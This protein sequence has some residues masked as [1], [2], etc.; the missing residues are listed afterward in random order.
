MQDLLNDNGSMRLKKCRRGPMRY[1]A[2]DTAVG[3]LLDTYGEFSEGEVQMLAKLVTH[4][5][6]V[7]EVGAN[8]G[9]LTVPLAQFVGPQGNVV[10]FEPQRVLFQTLCANVALNGLTNVRTVHAA[11]GAESGSVT[12]PKIDYATP[13][14]FGAHSIED[15]TD[16]EQ[17]QLIALDRFLRTDRCRLI[18]IDVEGMEAQVIEGARALI[19]AQKPILYVENDR[20]DRS[21]ELIRLLLNLGY[22][23]YWHLP[24]L[25]R[26]DNFSAQSMSSWPA[27]FPSTCFACRRP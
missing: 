8:I 4:G 12:L 17:V 15:A 13:G 21:S 19:Q 6:T 20:Q 24:P 5:D 26:D 16:G 7:I 14:M 23:L 11:V 9:A 2:N 10:A 3:G 27:T 22:R 25:A 1:S 18:K